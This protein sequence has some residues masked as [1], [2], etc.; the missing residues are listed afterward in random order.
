MKRQLYEELLKWK[1]SSKRK[2]LLLQGARQVGKTYLVNEFG[3][4]EY[5]NYIY[6]NFEER[7]DLQS[8]FEENLSPPNIIENI[9]LLLG[10]KIESANTLIFFDEIQL[11]PQALSSL[12]YFYEKNPEF[13][14]IAAGSLL[15]VSINKQSSF[16]VGKINFMKM[17]PL[18]FEEYLL[19]GD[20]SLLAEKIKENKNLRPF[21][22]TIHKKLMSELKMY[23]F[24]GGMPEV[25]Q[26]YFSN[27]DIASARNIQN[28]LLNAYRSDFSKY[29]EKGQ[30]IKTP[31]LWRSIPAQL[32]RENKKFKYGDVKKNARAATFE[33]T[34][35]W[36]KGAGL[37]NPAYNI[38]V[39]KI[40]VSA[41][42][43]YSKFKVYLFDTGL[44][45]AMLEI[46]SELIIDTTAI[47]SEFNGA[48]M[49]NYVAMEL[50]ASGMED[51][52]Y[53]TSKSDA[54]VDFIV[55]ADNNIFP[56]EV[57]S[58]KSKKLSSLRSYE[59]KYS[60]ENIYR[61]S[62]RNFYQDGTFANIPLY[63]IFSFY[64]YLK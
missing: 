17:H 28:E 31:E 21:P 60:P 53:W 13:H 63:S 7:P 61:S 25:L 36:L 24:L 34:I 40:P 50:T 3:N 47:F 9:G 52:F 58:G 44:L 43:D 16:P 54:E 45:G 41:Y 57:K 35:E 14:I 19:A 30:A 12:K 11:L 39:P 27:K 23:L 42:A 46:S 18:S 62:P 15:G 33:Q 20:N 64:N 10:H 48:F 22:E 29:T 37:I 26:D 5:S 55:Q 51:L 8:L 2:P 6:L 4:K 1:N 56:L 49:E 38:S 32:A 59:K